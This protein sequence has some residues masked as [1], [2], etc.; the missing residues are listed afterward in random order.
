MSACAVPGP[1]GGMNPSVPPGPAR[2]APGNGIGSPDGQGHALVLRQFQHGV[3]VTSPVVAPDLE[4]IDH[5][6]VRAR[7][8]LEVLDAGILAFVRALILET[9]AI[10]DF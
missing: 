4:D 2:P 10:D 6:F 9:V 5:A 3:Q 8:R 7:D 1:S